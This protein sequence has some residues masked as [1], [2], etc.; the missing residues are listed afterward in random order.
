MKLAAIALSTAAAMAWAPAVLASSKA[1]GHEMQEHGKKASDR[2]SSS[3][4]GHRMRA[5]KSKSPE[6]S[7]NAPA[8]TREDITKIGGGGGG[9]GGG[10]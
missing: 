8:E 6:V 4:P 9:G 10:M 7:G 1:P 2:A 5:D 3:A